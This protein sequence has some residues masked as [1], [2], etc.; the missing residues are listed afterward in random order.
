MQKKCN[1]C[2]SLKD[3]NLFNKRK[4]S[5]DGYRTQ[6]RKCENLYAR[7]WR[8]NNPEKHAKFNK[9]SYQRLS[10]DSAW[11]RDKALYWR[12]KRQEN[13]SKY[14]KHVSNYYKRNKGTIEA[15]LRLI[16]SNLFNRLKKSNSRTLGYNV[17]KLKQRIEFNFKDGMTWDNYGEWHIDHVKPV[18]RFIKQGIH[19]PKVI[20]SLSNL[21]PLWASENISKGDK[22][23]ANSR[24][25]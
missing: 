17:Y 11:M 10:K 12:K 6:C 19:D 14:N 13:P 5:R 25:I 18:S 4:S 2:Q 21:R 24:G 7:E 22:F 23:H 3:L 16:S 1:K 8:K 20:N 15:K 9:E